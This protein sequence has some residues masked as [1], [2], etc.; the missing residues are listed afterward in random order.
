MARAIP[1]HSLPV[2]SIINLPAPAFDFRS[3]AA[4]L[5]DKPKSWSSFDVVK[6]IRKCV[7]LRKVGHAG[8]LDPMATG[9]VIVCCGKGTKTIAEIQEQPKSYIGEITLGAATPSY[10]A[11]TD[12]KERAPYEHITKQQVLDA[13]DDHF[14][15][16]IKQIPPMYSALKKQGQPLYKMARKGEEVERE[17]RQITIHAARIISFDLPKIQLYVKCSKG[18]YI[19]SIAHDLGQKLNSLGYLSALRRTAIGSYNVDDALTIE[20]LDLLFSVDTE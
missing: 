17:P 20:D 2:F 7:D 1:L 9:M 12:I 16:G 4:F 10:D 3:G 6:Q 8:T 14:S 13:L 18:T 11:E 5:V 19:R 15:G